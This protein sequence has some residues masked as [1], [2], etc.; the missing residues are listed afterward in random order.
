M[1][2]P[3]SEYHSFRFRQALA[4]GLFMNVAECYKENEY[5]TV[6]FIAKEAPVP[7]RFRLDQRSAHCEDSS[8]LGSLRRET[9]AGRIH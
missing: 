1:N 6:E 4:Q 7:E 3:V 9:V 2:V 5:R 8:E